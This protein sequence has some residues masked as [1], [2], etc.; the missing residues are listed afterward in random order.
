MVQVLASPGNFGPRTS[1]NILSAQG[2]VTG[3]FD[4]ATSNFG[5][6]LPSLAYTG[7]DVVLMNSNIA[8]RNFQWLGHL[9][10]N[11]GNV[12]CGYMYEELVIR[13]PLGSGSMTFETTMR[14]H[15]NS[16]QAFGHCRSLRKCL[17]RIALRHSR[18]KIC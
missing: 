10:G 14:D 11:A 1:F 2:G 17:V 9:R 3:A 16:I 6:L 7:T 13:R 12:L 15:R 8:G 18:P 5:F 4:A